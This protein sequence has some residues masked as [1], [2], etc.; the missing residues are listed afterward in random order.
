[1][2]FKENHE[3]CLS[4]DIEM[5]KIIYCP[6]CDNIHPNNCKYCGG[7]GVMI[8]GKNG[9]VKIKK[10]SDIKIKNETT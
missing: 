10:K 1:M 7:Y 8:K 9:F 3:I 2:K 5:Y 6:F 4:W